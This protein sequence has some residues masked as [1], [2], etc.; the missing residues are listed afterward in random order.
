MSSEQKGD[1]N[2]DRHLASYSRRRLRRGSR[3]E[4][5]PALMLMMVMRLRLYR[6]AAV[7]A[8]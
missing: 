8:A 3:G 5:V 6:L 2:D 1:S 4:D 7:V